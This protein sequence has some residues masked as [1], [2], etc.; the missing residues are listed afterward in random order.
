MIFNFKIKY[1]L[2]FSLI[3][4][5]TWF[6][7]SNNPLNPVE[8]GQ[9]NNAP[10]QSEQNDAVSYAE[11]K[12]AE[13]FN[14]ALQA[15]SSEDFNNLEK[16]LAKVDLQG[17]IKS[18]MQMK[19]LSLKY[20]SVKTTPSI[21]GLPS[22]TGDDFIDGTVLLS[23]TKGDFFSDLTYW[24]LIADY[25]HSG[26]L[27]KDQATDDPDK[28]CVLTADL[29]GVTYQTYN[30]WNNSTT[31][32]KIDPTNN[33]TPDNLNSAQS[34]IASYIEKTTYYAFITLRLK[35]ISRDDELYWY[36]S[37]TVWR[38]FDSSYMKMDVENEYFYFD[39]NQRFAK[40]R[41]SGMY[42]LYYAFLKHFLPDWLARILADAK[43][44]EIVSE[45]I[46]PDEVA[47]ATSEYGNGDLVES[48]RHTWGDTSSI[49]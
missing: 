29:R 5:L 45:L 35:P 43:L 17:E 3:F 24:F 34:E 18:S 31:V 1:L 9:V 39:E 15:K 19:G 16:L 2:I 14:L 13:F 25:T 42:Q 28:G 36:C 20:S 8:Q 41:E 27:D 11:E 21:L 12:T 23:K 37:K 30:E 48:S 10:G 38:L 49:W 40:L 44:K 47:Y 22:F 6:S 26:D 4:S 7:C 46:T 33:Y 32:T